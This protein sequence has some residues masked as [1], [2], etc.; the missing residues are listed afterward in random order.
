MCLQL[1]TFGSSAQCQDSS[2]ADVAD[3]G[4][5]GLSSPLSPPSTS[6]GGGLLWWPIVVSLGGAALI[7]LCAFFTLAIRQRNKRENEVVFVDSLPPEICKTWRSTDGLLQ[8][9]LVPKERGT[10][11]GGDRA[12]TVPT[13]LLASDSILRSLQSQP[14]IVPWQPMMISKHQLIIHSLFFSNRLLR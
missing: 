7:G 2:F 13:G 11:A 1:S 6:G 9:S 5:L 10:H 8:G 14:G 3:G 12:L 4:V